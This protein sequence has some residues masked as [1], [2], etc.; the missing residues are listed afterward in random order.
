MNGA[1]VLLAVAAIL[2]SLAATMRVDDQRFPVRFVGWVMG[3]TAAWM[4]ANATGAWS[5]WW[6]A[7]AIALLGVLGSLRLNRRLL[8]IAADGLGVVI[9]GYLSIPPVPA[10]QLGGVGAAMIVFGFIADHVLARSPRQRRTAVVVALLGLPLIAGIATTVARPGL[11]RDRLG[12]CADGFL[13]K[14]V[15]SPGGV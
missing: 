15:G 6:P 14:D 2:R 4:A 3:A 9:T 5:P 1:I 7:L 11:V 13:G 10:A 8:W 12:Y